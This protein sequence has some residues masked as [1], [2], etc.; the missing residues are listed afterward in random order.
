M[1]TLNSSVS[2]PETYDDTNKLV[3]KLKARLKSHKRT[4]QIIIN[5]GIHVAVL[6][7]L[8]FTTLHYVDKEENCTDNC[9]MDFCNGFGLLVLVLAVVYYSLTY[10]YVLKPTIGKKIY[11]TVKRAVGDDTERVS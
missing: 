8:T 11:R 9:G 5:L 3:G 2:A 7:Y 6:V 10:Y 4:I 1:E